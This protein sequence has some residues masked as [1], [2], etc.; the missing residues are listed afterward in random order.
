[1]SIIKSNQTAIN[2]K[3]NKPIPIWK[4]DTETITVYHF[5]TDIQTVEQKTYC[6]DFIRYHIHY[7]EFKCP[8]RLCK[9]V[10][11]GTIISYIDDLEATVNKALKQQVQLWKD[12][13]REY[14]IAVA[15]GN[16]EKQIG[17][18]NCFLFMARES[19]FDCLVYC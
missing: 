17:L 10:N 2:P 6:T 14:Q 13:D 8:D 16:T 5:N 19:V 18:E 7:S 15:V 9:L 1:M 4:L 12:T 11:D 3:T